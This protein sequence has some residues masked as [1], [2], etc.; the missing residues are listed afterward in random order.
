VTARVEEPAS[1]ADDHDD[2]SAVVAWDSWGRSQRMLLL[3]RRRD[4]SGHSK[5]WR[6]ILRGG[7]LLHAGLSHGDDHMEPIPRQLCDRYGINAD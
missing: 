6:N 2:D 3:S 5:N 4:E 7:F 1:V